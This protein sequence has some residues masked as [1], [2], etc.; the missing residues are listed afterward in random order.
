MKPTDISHRD[1][2]L[3]A[4]SIRQPRT[5]THRPGRL[6]TVTETTRI[7]RY[8]ERLRWIFGR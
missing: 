3:T 7:G 8:L 4:G 6:P 1:Y 2:K 5:R